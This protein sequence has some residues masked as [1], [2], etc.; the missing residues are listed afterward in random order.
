M[1]LCMVLVFLLL[2][3]RLGYIQFVQGSELKT[4]AYV[5]QTLDRTINP[6][7][8]TIYDRNGEVLAM[9]ASVETITVNPTNIAKEDKEKVAKALTNIFE[10]DYET[11][12]KKVNRKTS[13]ETIVKKVDKEKTDKLRKWM[14]SENIINGINI[15]EDTKRYYPFATL[16]SHIIGFTGSDNQGLDG[17]EAKYDEILSGEKGKI[18]RKTDASGRIIGDGEEQ[19]VKAIDGDSIELSIDTNIQ[20]IATKYLEEACIDNECE[21]GGVVIIMEPKTGDILAMVAYPE[22]NLNDP[23]TI[24]TEEITSAWNRIF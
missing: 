13:I 20:S 5:Q 23:F 7:R 17:I 18:E 16:A 24:N 11:I 3:I 19:Y 1:F 4:M 8:G 9:S 6:N 21:E 2:I 14:Q 12:L 10:L 22:Y 15:D